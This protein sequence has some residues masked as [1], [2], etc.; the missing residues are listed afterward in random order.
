MK[1]TAYLHTQGVASTTWTVTH[2][3]NTPYFGYFVYDNNH[4][5]VIASVTVIDNNSVQINLAEAITGT[6]VFF[7]IQHVSA[8]NVNAIDSITINTLTVRDSSGVLTINNNAVAMAESVAASLALIYTKTQSDSLLS[9]AVSAE[10]GLREAADTALSDR[11]DGVLSNIDSAA[12][13]SL[14]EIVTAFQAADGTL[15]GA[16]TSLS[17]SA[18]S[19]LATEVTNRGTAVTAAIATAA[20]DATAKVLIETTARQSADATNSAAIT[21]EFNRAVAAE[22]VL[23]T[24]VSN[25]ASARVLGDSNTLADGKAYAD[26]IVST[27]ASARATAVT[28]AITTAASDATAKVLTETNARIA[29]DAAEVTARNAAIASATPSFDTLTGKPTTI[30]G[31]GITDALT[32]SAIATAIGV[33][34]TRATAAEGTLTTNLSSEVANRASADTAAIATA[35]A[36]TD[37]AI[38]PAVKTYLGAVTGD[39][40]PAVNLVGNLG[41][42]THQFHSLYVGPGTLYVNGKAVIQDNSDTMTFS[43]DANQNMRLQTSGSGHL[44]LQAATGTIDV[45][46]TL[47]IESGK[48]IVDSAGTQVQFGD[49]IQMNTNKVIGLGAPT[50]NTDAATKKYV[51]DLTTYDTTLVRTSGVQSIAGVKTFADGIVV[52]GNLTVSG[53]T[54][55]VNSE[56]IKLADNLI[57]LNSNFTS[58][59]PTENSGLRIMRGDEPGAQLRWNESTDKWETSADSVNF[60]TIAS[61]TDVSAEATLRTSGDATTLASGKTYADSG[62]ATILASAKSYADAGDS[63]EASARNVAIAANLVTAK[64]YADA[65]DVTTLASG[66]TYADGIVATEATARGTAVTAAIATAATAADA[67]VLVETNARIAAV[68]AAIATAATAA[69]AKVL[70]ETNARIAADSAEVTA[71]N[72]A[73]TAGVVTSASKLTTARTI[74]GVSFDGTSNIVVTAAAGTLTGTIDGG[75]Y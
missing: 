6:A 34:T 19:A 30:A 71:R 37:G 4:K 55:T 1:Q 61:T 2:N 45:K 40:I 15:N 49:D 11:I 23:T 60:L 18:A 20:S 48:R 22:L 69:D 14:S 3:F 58:G 70:V 51:D 43:T 29:A 24:S 63:T 5:L 7:S 46:G 31:Y 64:S 56:T 47:S 21:S 28:S 38:V 50:A 8:P 68:T 39:I 75:S 26:G 73:I 16:I 62:D 52:S 17:T 54:T 65:G 10:A 35:A 32:A 42:I 59:A 66:K 41:S 13:D 44:E 74:N 25:E 33:E 72:S 27:E 9:A 36:Y 53:T 57:D 12:L 67:K